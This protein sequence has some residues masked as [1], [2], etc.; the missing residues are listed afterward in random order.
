MLRTRLI[1]GLLGIVPLLLAAALADDR[2][3]LLAE[4]SEEL[5][6]KWEEQFRAADADQDSRLTRAEVEAAK[7]PAAIAERFAEID[8]D[9]DGGLAPEELL[10]VHERRLREQRVPAATP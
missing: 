5:H 3:A 2:E 4:R 9:A 8:A 10:A 7:L 1:C 6:R